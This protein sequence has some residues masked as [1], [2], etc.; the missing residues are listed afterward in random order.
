M[1]GKNYPIEVAELGMCHRVEVPHILRSRKNQSALM[2]SLYNFEQTTFRI[3]IVH[4]IKITLF[5]LL[6]EPYRESFYVS[7]MTQKCVPMSI[8]GYALR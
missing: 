1:I 5:V 3:Q 4:P 8:E 2:F 6:R 7:A